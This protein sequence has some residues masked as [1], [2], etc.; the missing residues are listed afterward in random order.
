MKNVF[1]FKLK[2]FFVVERFTFLS[3]VLGYIEK[4][5]DRKLMVNFK[6]YNVRD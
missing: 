3:C 5:L 4:R 1:Y 6:I 2:A